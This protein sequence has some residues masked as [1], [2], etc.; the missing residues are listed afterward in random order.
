MDQFCRRGLYSFGIARVPAILDP[1]VAAISP[2]E[3]LERVEE[4]RDAGLTFTIGLRVIRDQH[5]NPPGL[6]RARRKRPSR[7]RATEQRDEVAPPKSHS[8][9]SSAM[10]SKRGRNSQA[11]RLGRLEIDD[12]FKLSVLLDR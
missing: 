9:T 4:R 10:A 8:I 7:R 5:T 6:L 2:A 3:P 12:Q 1:D 11:K